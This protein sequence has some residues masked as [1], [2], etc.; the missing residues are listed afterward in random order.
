MA[1]THYTLDQARAQLPWLTQILAQIK[2]IGARSEQLR[3]DVD[4]LVGR[5][6]A[7]GHAAV[8]DAI[9]DRHNEAQ[10]TQDELENLAGQIA[11]RN[12]ILRDVQRGLIDFPSLRGG[13]EVYLCWVLGETDI[14]YW[15]DTDAGFAGRQP[16]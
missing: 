7:N 14:E 5:L 8:D 9:S 12:I 15:H 1:D 10:H 13:R 11:E 2:E 3:G 6:Q 4:R 16:L